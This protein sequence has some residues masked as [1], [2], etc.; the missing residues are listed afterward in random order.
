MIANRKLLLFL[1]F[2]AAIIAFFDYTVFNFL[3]S[4]GGINIATEPTNLNENNGHQIEEA[5]GH[6]EKEESDMSRNEVERNS[7][8]EMP[9]LDKQIPE[10]L[11][12][13]TFAMG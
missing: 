10:N 11:Q 1:L 9:P 3:F 8:L 6:H 5:Y 2:A 12:T 7:A 4:S 13:A